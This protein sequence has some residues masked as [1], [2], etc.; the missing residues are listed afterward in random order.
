MT[1]G[2]VPGQRP[3][4]SRAMAK[5]ALLAAGLLAAGWVLRE[6]AVT[7]GAEWVDRLVRGQ[8]GWGQA[9]F[10]LG[11][12]AATAAGVP[13][14]VVGFL[15]GYAFGV[16]LGSALAM[17][18]QLLGCALAYGWARVIG[19]E[20]AARLLA[21]RYGRRLR[22]L[23]D[24][25]ARAPFAATLALRLLPIG[26][27]L[28]LNLLAGLA[29]VPVLA[30]LAGSAVGYLPQTVVFALLGKGIRV[31]GAWQ[32][33][34]AGGLLAVSLGLGLWLLRRNRAAAALAEAPPE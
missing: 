11:G 2:A 34:L 15:G 33:A 24:A 5:L 27:N 25:L 8:G 1:A 31:D 6:L 26:N 22:R 4:L 19:R 3:R 23:T 7:P 16:V 28:A 32:L 20:V 17:A 12:A 29:G 30:F 14:Q 13:R 10:V 9:V 18:A 21:G